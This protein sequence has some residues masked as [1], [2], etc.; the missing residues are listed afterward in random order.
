LSVLLADAGALESMSAFLPG[1]AASQARLPELFLRLER[2]A[3]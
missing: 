2:L 1:D 3:G